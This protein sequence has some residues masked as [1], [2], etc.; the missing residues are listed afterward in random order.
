MSNWRE[1]IESWECPTCGAPPGEHCW[2][3]GGN[4]IYEPH[5]DRGRAANRCPQCGARLTAE[6]EPGDICARCTLVRALETE[7]ATVYHRLEP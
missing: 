6:Q 7:R 1:T 4:R 3:T 2:T 5:A